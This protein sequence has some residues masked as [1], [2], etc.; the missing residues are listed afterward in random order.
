[1]P[2]SQY[3]KIL[4]NSVTLSLSLFRKRLHS[5]YTV[6]YEITLVLDKLVDRWEVGKTVLF[7]VHVTLKLTTSSYRFLPISQTDENHYFLYGII[8]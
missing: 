8:K 2:V 5:S 6:A 3:T 1:M 7:A 4:K